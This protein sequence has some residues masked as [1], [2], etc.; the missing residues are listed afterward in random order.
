[1]NS[2]PMSELARLTPKVDTV[3]EN[4]YIVIKARPCKVFFCLDFDG[5]FW[6]FVES[7]F[8]Y[9]WVVMLMFSDRN[10]SV[11]VSMVFDWNSYS[12]C[13]VL[14]V[15]SLDC[16][17]IWKFIFYVLKPLRV[18]DWIEFVFDGNFCSS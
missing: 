6:I 14:G 3:H 2:R 15:W 7:G 4:G 1:M 13:N 10:R 12:L 5:F 18:M 16:L 9:C 17:I 11:F 8:Y